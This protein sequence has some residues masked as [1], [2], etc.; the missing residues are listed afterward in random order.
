MKLVISGIQPTGLV[1]LGNYL[2]T[3]KPFK[4]LQANHDT[5]FLIADQHSISSSYFKASSGQSISYNLISS[6]KTTF[7]TLKAC[8]IKNLI[9]QSQVP[10]LCQLA[11][12]LGCIS[13]MSSYE[14]M[15][16]FQAK[17]EALT[18]SSLAIISYPVLMAADILLFKSH[19]VLIGDDQREHLCLC[20]DLAIRFNSIFGEYFPIPQE[21]LAK[22]PRIM[23]LRD[24]SKKMSKSSRSESTKINIL[25]SPD[26][27]RK[28]IMKAKTDCIMEVYYDEV[29][30]MEL[31]NMI[32]IYYGIVGEDIV[33][34]E[35]RK[36]WKDVLEFKSDLCDVVIL[37]MGKI[38]E[39]YY[40][41]VYEDKFEKD[42]EELVDKLKEVGRK[43]L[44]EIKK[45]VG[46]F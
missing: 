10:E 7:L 43:N 35:V 1:H 39:K 34:K 28:K 23:N 17:K 20:Q 33:E 4:N 27:I 29:N 41:A 2:G 8:G 13:S 36:R 11:W 40:E 26:N 15:S 42:E 37:E 38:R 21:I 32:R 45:I 44:E 46:F 6:I 12:I 9:F 31:A 14:K 19:Q 22:T 30:R 5:I 3:I 16:Q 24:A 25:D 18:G